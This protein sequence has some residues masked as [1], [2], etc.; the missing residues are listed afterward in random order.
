[1]QDTVS[2]TQARLTAEEGDVAPC[3]ASLGPLGPALHDEEGAHV[4]AGLP[5]V[6]D[7]H[8]HLFPERMFAAMWRWFD[9]HG[10]PIRYKLQSEQIVEFMRQRGVER[11][12]ALHYAHKPGIARSMNEAMSALVQHHP[13]VIGTATVMPGEPE[14]A[15]ILEAGFQAGLRGAKLHCHVQGLAVD[16]D[17]MH[18]LYEVAVRHDRPMVV[19]AGREPRS[20]GYRVDPHTICSADRTERVLR[21]HPRLRLCIPHLGADELEAYE[22]LLERYDNLWLDTTMMLAEYFPFR[23]N[24]RMLTVRPERILYG[25]DFPILPYA[26]DRELRK[27]EGYG[28]RDETLAGILGANAL[29]LFAPDSG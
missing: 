17:S 7:A 25:T 12:V 9:Q 15:A 14:A 11:F 24:A 6:V 16:D 23:P 8:V 20:A 5:P 3:G 1:M 21:A 4:P 22:S 2:E 29:R 28:L 19:H 18:E 26:W 13:Q 27:L 10:W